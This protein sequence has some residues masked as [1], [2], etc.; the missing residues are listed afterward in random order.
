[1][2]KKQ[3]L[4]LEQKKERVK[5]FRPLDDVFFEVLADDRDFCQ[6]LLRTVM[7]DS[8]LKVCDVIVQ[9]SRRNLYGRSVRLDALCKLGS[10]DM[11][12]VEVQRADEDDHFRRVR[13][14]ASVITA[15]E[16]YPGARFEKIC[17]VHVV[18]ISEFDIIGKGRTSYHVD[19]VIRETGTLVDDG[20]HR[21]FVNTVNDDGTDTSELMSCF[22]KTMVDNPKFPVFTRRMHELKEEEGGLDA[23]CEVMQKYIREA[24]AE[25]EKRIEEANKGTAEAN[26]KKMLAIRSMIQY[27][28]P[29]EA[30]LRDFSEE[31]YLSAKK[32]LE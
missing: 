5:D 7:E 20:L 12:N 10:G 21:I 29:R 6:E 13:Y 32:M 28:I 30:I 8:G 4:T 14:H 22:T 26:R 27:G 19:S 15:K 24:T 31:E 1:M 23:V 16:S 11:C 3:T 9:S 17:N 2:Q 25:A 18:Y